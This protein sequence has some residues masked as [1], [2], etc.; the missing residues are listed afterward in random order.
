LSECP[1]WK[2]VELRIALL[3]LLLKVRAFLQG[4]KIAS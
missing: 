3:N 2:A 1:N 4:F